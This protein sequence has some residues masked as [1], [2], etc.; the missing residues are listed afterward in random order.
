MDPY[1]V[2]DLM[3][4]C[5]RCER[6][7]KPGDIKTIHDLSCRLHEHISMVLYLQIDGSFDLCPT[8]ANEILSEAIVSIR[9]KIK[10]RT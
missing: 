10:E 2:G 9:E 4:A 1:Q 8:C 5:D 6:V 7:L 3:R